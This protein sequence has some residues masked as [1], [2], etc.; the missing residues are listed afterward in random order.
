MAV[1]LGVVL[2]VWSSPALAQDED[3]GGGGSKPALSGPS[4]EVLITCDSQ[5]LGSRV[6]KGEITPFKISVTDRGTT[7]RNVLIRMDTSDVDGDTPQW[8]RPVTTTPGKAVSIWIYA[9]VPFDADVFNVTAHEAIERAGGDPDD[10]SKTTYD[11]GRRLGSTALQLRA[12]EPVLGM[13]LVIGTSRA[14]LDQYTARLTSGAMSPMLGHEAFELVSGIKPGDLPDRPQ[15]LRGFDAVI[16]TGT[17]AEEQ[18]AKLNVQQADA[19]REWV[20][21]GGHLVIIVPTVGQTWI[22]SAANPLADIMPK[23]GVTRRDNVDLAPFHALLTRELTTDEKTQ[24]KQITFPSASVMHTFEP[25]AEAGPYDAMPILNTPADEQGKSEI[26]AVR[27]IVNQGAVTLIGIDLNHPALTG[28]SL[29]A[30][31]FWHRVFGRRWNL[32]SEKSITDSMRFPPSREPSVT[33][34]NVI[35]LNI[36]RQGRSA[37]GLLLAIVV[38]SAFWLIACP[39]SF[40]VLKNRRRTHHA[41]LAFAGFIGVFTAI[42]WTGAS[43][44]RQRNPDARFIAVI[45][46]VYGQPTQR[47]RVWANLFL[48]TYGTQRVSVADSVSKD[49]KSRPVLAPWEP[50]SNNTTSKPFPNVQGYSIDSRSPEA[51]SFPSRSTEKRVQIDWAGPPKWS[52]PLPI[53]PESAASAPPGA[54]FGTEIAI[55]P[56]ERVVG[57]QWFTLEGSLKHDLPYALEDVTVIVVGRQSALS[58][59]AP[60][61]ELIAIAGAWIYPKAW[62]PGETLS[63]GALTTPRAE[64]AKSVDANTYLEEKLMPQASSSPSV[65]SDAMPD[66]RTNVVKYLNGISLYPLLP[67]PKPRDIGRAIVVQRENTHGFDIARW[68]TQPCLI[69]LGHIK[70]GESPVPIEV[71]G[72]EITT[73]GHTMVRWIYP[74]APNPPEYQKKAAED[75]SAK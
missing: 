17:S 26:I 59:R 8:S 58:L 62:E 66:M 46:H 21:S 6:R 49:S 75:E 13:M 72:V 29:R 57:W 54:A 9:R 48:P 22:E 64:D 70:K 71:D 5:G 44:L 39:L 43:L 74:L 10:P 38:F 41:W 51:I 67:M 61:D 20:T 18:P 40:F 65:G 36:Q 28:D 52:M 31:F 14:G 24:L 15:G 63:L 11:A 47:A 7:I 35:D 12:F 30:D 68:F 55:K 34:D 53:A 45:D 73:S 3:D 60:N 32:S 2:G 27:R 25:L 69:V 56:L 42:S 4:G 16:W 23:V 50:A 37:G 33:L 1:V 19:L